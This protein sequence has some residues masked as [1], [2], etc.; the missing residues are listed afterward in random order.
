MSIAADSP[1]F[2]QVGMN[3]FIRYRIPLAVVAALLCGALWVGCRKHDETVEAEKNLPVVRV[4]TPEVKQ[5]TDYAYYTGRT[6]AVDSV[7][8]RSHVTGYLVPWNFEKHSDAAPTK[9]FDFVAGQDVSKNQVLFKIDP[10]TFQAAYDQAKAQVELSKAQLT[11]AKADYARALDVAKTP[12]AIS[13]Q[14]VDKYL[15]SQEKAVAEVAAQE[16]NAEVAHVNLEFTDV[17][18]LVGGVVS[19]N[20]VSVGNLVNANETVL[21][22]IVS[23]DPMYVYFYVDELILL[24]VQ[25]AIR[26]GRLKTV[27]KGQR[28]PI[29][30]ALQTDVNDYPYTAEMDFV[31]NQLDP[32][33]GTLQIRAELA[34]PQPKIGPRVF[35]PGMFVRVRVP[36][37]DP[38]TALVVPQLAIGSDQGNRY[39]WI[40]NEQNVVQYRPVTAG[41]EQ[42]GGMQE[43]FPVKIVVE[44]DG[45][46]HPAKEGEQGEDSIT[47]KDRIVVGGL[48]RITA[49]TKIQVRAPKKKKKECNPSALAPRSSPLPPCLPNSLSS[50]PSSPGSSPLSFCSWAAW[51][52]SRFQFLSIPTS[53]RPPCRSPPVI[54]VPTARSWPTASPRRSNS[55]STASKA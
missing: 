2:R 47:A 14:D 51:R 53:P 15:A 24:R 40:V 39:V 8:L 18:T 12:G 17:T 54:P 4:A 48:Q 20:L 16:A 26:D 28:L 6:E 3:L 55:K 25:N 30:V 19:R 37:S 10:R 32:S 45:G 34:N 52:W 5:V 13:K 35:D 21:T 43:I 23:Q 22:T 46:Y 38:H 44:K 1:N 33:T 11:L 41:Q 7:Q 50:G 27:G 36:I 31:N 49:G 29:G 42:P 9:D